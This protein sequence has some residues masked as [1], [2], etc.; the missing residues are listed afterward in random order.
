MSWH[1]WA[2][3]WYWRA[4]AVMVPGLLNSQYLYAAELRGAVSAS[5]RW[6]DLGCG[7]AFLPP[8]ISRDQV[9]ATNG[10][11]VVGIDADAEALARHASLR[12]RIRANIEALPLAAD[13][14]NLITANMVVEHVANPQPLF[15]EVRRVLAPGGRFLI[16]TPNVHGYTTGLARVVPRSMRTRLAG[17]LHR[18]DER[19]VYPTFYRA[20]SKR[21]LEQLAARSGLSLVRLQYVE[22]SAQLAAVPPLFIGEL[23][24]IRALRWSWGE[25]LRPCILALFEKRS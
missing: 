21:S 23:A 13:T 17:L 6:L 15:D 9:F 20:N 19:D 11:Q 5:E 8:W 24:L 3:S 7:H 12:H 14:C 18:R 10:C 22:S 16:H 2:D 4:Q 1:Q 25:S